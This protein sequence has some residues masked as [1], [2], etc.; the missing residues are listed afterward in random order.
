VDGSFKD[1]EVH[2]DIAKITLRLAA[3]ALLGAVTP[4]AALL[5]TY[6]T[7]PG[8]HKEVA[9]QGGPSSDERAALQTAKREA[10]P[11]HD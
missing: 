11:R 1:P 10:A 9:C 4:P 5:A 7:G 6:E 3:A 8:K 2:P